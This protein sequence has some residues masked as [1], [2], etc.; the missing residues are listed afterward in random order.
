MDYY[1][2][3]GVAKTASQ[4]EIKKAYR[5]LAMEHHPD[6]GGDVSK[7]QEITTAYETLSDTG[8]RFQYDNPQAR[9][10]FNQQPGFNFNMNQF[11]LNNLFSQ[12]FDQQHDI[13]GQ[14]KNTNQKQVFRTRVIV[15]LMDS[16][17]GNDHALQLG[18]PNGVKLINIK[19]P[20][21]V[22]NGDQVRYDNLIENATLIIEFMVQP[23]LKFDRQHNDLYYNIPIS[24]LD[25]IVGTKIEVPTISGKKL[26]VVIKPGTQPTQQIRLPGYGMPIIQ[27]NYCGDQILLLKPFIPDNIPDEIIAS[28]KNNQLNN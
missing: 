28:I 22:N 27:Q 8:K 24:V 18:T 4:D 9:P 17:N 10:T 15:S 14:T 11:D 5:K 12:I 6:K 23:D 16:F 7:F 1:N 13:F 2:I 3:L 21:G 26:E 19:V 25:L 20:K